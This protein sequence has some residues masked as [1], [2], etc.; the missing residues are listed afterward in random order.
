MVIFSFVFHLSQITYKI[1]LPL[2]D[3]FCEHFGPR[4]DSNFVES[5]MV[6][7]NLVKVKNQSFELKNFL[8]SRYQNFLRACVY[9]L[10]DRLGIHCLP[11]DSCILIFKRMNS[12]NH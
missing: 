6:Q 7:K 2:R 11:N 4:S 10:I 12:V 3:N 9:Y 1:S 5:D 8:S